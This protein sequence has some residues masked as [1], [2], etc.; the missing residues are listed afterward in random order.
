MITAA[1]KKIKIKNNI[2]DDFEIYADEKMLEATLRNLAANAIK[3]TNETGQIELNARLFDENTIE[4]TVTDNG[5]G[6]GADL[7]NN[8][9][10]IEK[11]ISTPG[12]KNEQG[13]GLG[14]ILCKEFVEKNGGTL[15]V[16]STLKKGSKFK[17]T[18]P[19]TFIN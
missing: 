19:T 3:Y 8:L 11:K 6:I 18:V 5:I 17:F 12:T 13:T 4:I 15:K 7:I 16:E 14:L 9:F 1:E 2:D 10:K